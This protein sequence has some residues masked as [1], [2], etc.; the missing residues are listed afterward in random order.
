[1][2]S[3]GKKEGGAPTVG[4]TVKDGKSDGK[5]EG[6]PAENVLEL[7]EEDDE[8]EEFEGANWEDAKG[9]AED[10]QLWQDDWVCFFP[11]SLCFLSLAR[12][13]PRS[14]INPQRLGR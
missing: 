9:D 13:S 8:F 6:V 2:S 7:L 10:G 14:Q 11:F 5:K 12:F 1:M 4:A 3:P